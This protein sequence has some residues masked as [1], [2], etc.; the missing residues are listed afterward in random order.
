MSVIGFPNYQPANRQQAEFHASTARHKLLI[1]GYGG[2]K[3]YPAYHEVGFHCLD[4]PGHA[5]LICRNTWKDLEDL[6]WKDVLEIFEPAGIIKSKVFKSGDKLEIR[7]VNDHVIMFKPLSSKRDNVKGLHICQFYLDDPDVKRYQDM[8]SFLK[9]RLR[10][11]AG[12]KATRFQSIITANWEGRDW[13]WKTYMKEREEGGDGEDLIMAP[14]KNGEM[15]LQPSGKAFWMCPTS[16]NKHLPDNYIA[17]LAADH[18]AEWMDRYVFCKDVARHSGLIYYDFDY[19]KHHKDRTEVEQKAGLVYGLG[20]DVGGTHPTA[21][22]E[23]A[24]DG[25]NIYITGEWVKKNCKLSDLGGYLQERRLTGKYRRFIIDPSSAKGEQTSG[26]SVKRELHRKYQISFENGINDVE[27]GIEVIQDLL[28]NAHGETRIYF[29]VT[30]CPN[31]I[32]EIEVY[33]WEEGKQMDLDDMEYQRK[34][35][36]KNDDAVDAL[37]YLVM[38]LKKYIRGVANNREWTEMKEDKRL[39]RVMKLPYYKNNRRAR[40]RAEAKIIHRRMG[41][42]SRKVAKILQEI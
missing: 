29:D 13:L 10:N 15:E 36:K 33:R 4:N 22:I 6:A 8:I 25:K 31:L 5:S 32:R 26:S 17:D 12:H 11:T 30:R 23:G 38:W 3:S 37:R 28:L 7:L 42:D 19:K 24:T 2:G 40:E 20:V 41:T 27:T 21:V 16:G 14:N 1:G 9:S 34:P 39:E 35:R 18:S